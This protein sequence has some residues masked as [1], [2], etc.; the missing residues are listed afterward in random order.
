MKDYSEK[1]IG[2][3]LSNYKVKDIATAAGL[4]VSTINKYKRDPAFVAILNERRAAIVGAAVDRMNSSILNDVDV[5]QSVIDDE[6][7]NP[8]VRVNAINTKWVHLR[9]WK[10]LID[11]E[12][13]L[14][15]LEMAGFGDSERFKP[16]DDAE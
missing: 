11:F 12:N 5:L 2:A 7:V 9:E 4:A 10:A 8:A 13:R 15:A 14:R 1:V 16:G 3:F 6:K